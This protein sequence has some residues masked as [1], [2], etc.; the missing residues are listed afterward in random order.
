MITFD[1]WEQERNATITDT[2]QADIYRHVGRRLRERFGIGRKAFPL[3][4][5]NEMSYACATR[6]NVEVTRR[7]GMSVY[8]KGMFEGQEIVWVYCRD[9]KCITTVLEVETNEKR[10]EYVAKVRSRNRVS[11]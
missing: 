5:W 11:I 1:E 8:C 3:D 7:N 2:R 4:R 9:R 10:F 6:Q